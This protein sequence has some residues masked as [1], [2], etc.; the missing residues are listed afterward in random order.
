MN[1]L[2]KVIDDFLATGSKKKLMILFLKL[3][4]DLH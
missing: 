2:V 3:N 4:V 1:N